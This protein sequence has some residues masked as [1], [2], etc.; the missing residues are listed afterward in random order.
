MPLIDRADI[1]DLVVERLKPVGTQ[2]AAEFQRLG[3]MPTGQ[4]TDILPRDLR[5]SVFHGKDERA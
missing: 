5:K 2:A 3:H 1:A 4:V